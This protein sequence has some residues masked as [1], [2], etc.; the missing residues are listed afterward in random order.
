MIEA[1]KE[2][3]QAIL[4]PQIEALRGDMR[5]LEAKLEARIDVLAGRIDGLD[6]KIDAI[7][8]KWMARFDA[9][10]M[11]MESSR[12]EFSAEVRRIE[13]TLS[14]DF[15]RFEKVCDLHISILE[16]KTT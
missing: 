6:D 15:V 5:A 10:D 3:L 7:D 13:E 4:A 16:K 12:R 2:A 1:M 11:K 9:I 14:A 8:A